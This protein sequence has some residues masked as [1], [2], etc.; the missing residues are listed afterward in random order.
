MFSESSS[1]SCACACACA[2]SNICD[3]RSCGLVCN[4]DDDDDVDVD[5]MGK[6]SMAFGSTI[7]NIARQLISEGKGIIVTGSFWSVV[8]RTMIFNVGSLEDQLM[9][10]PFLHSE[11]ELM[12]EVRDR[13]RCVPLNKLKVFSRHCFYNIVKIAPQ[14]KL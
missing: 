11:E 7:K 13:A 2:C 4:D 6:E 5:M 1:M 3:T 9:V 8:S 10:P 12:V 14:A